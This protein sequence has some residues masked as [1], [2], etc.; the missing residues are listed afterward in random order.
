MPRRPRRKKCHSVQP[1]CARKPLK[2]NETCAK[3]VSHFFELAHAKS[4]PKNPTLTKRE[5]GTRKTNVRKINC[6]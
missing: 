4:K 5:W 3:E 1:F 2:T 6:N